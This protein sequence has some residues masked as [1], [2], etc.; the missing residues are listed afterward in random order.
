MQLPP[1]AAKGSRPSSGSFDRK[2]ETKPSYKDL[3][4]KHS[5]LRHFRSYQSL[6]IPQSPPARMT[7][8][9]ILIGKPLGA[10]VSLRSKLRMGIHKHA[11]LSA[12]STL[13]ECR[14]QV[15][16]YKKSAASLRRGFS[17]PWDVVLRER[18]EH[19]LEACLAIH[20]QT[21]HCMQTEDEPS[22]H[23]PHAARFITIHH[24]TFDSRVIPKVRA[25]R[26]MHKSAA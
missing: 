5:P 23:N 22:T 25:S 17:C 15:Y 26:K 6:R 13:A 19:A 11:L 21:T 2:R 24:Q 18:E 9:R 20:K 8:S 16:L 3:R 14:E 4:L 10:P 1:I 7:L 12:A